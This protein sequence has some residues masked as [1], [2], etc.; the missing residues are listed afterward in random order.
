[1]ICLL[2]TVPLARDEYEEVKA[3]VD[4]ILKEEEEEEEGP[5]HFS[6]L[7]WHVRG[8]ILACSR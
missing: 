6:L 2:C 7:S 4:H 5:E 3:E 1:M 8:N